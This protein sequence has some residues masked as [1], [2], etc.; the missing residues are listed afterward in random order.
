MSLRAASQKQTSKAFQMLTALYAGGIIV[1]QS[2]GQR[3]S[4]VGLITTS[5]PLCEALCGVG[6]SAVSACGLHARKRTSRQGQTSCSLTL[7]VCVCVC[8]SVRVCKSGH[9]C[10]NVCVCV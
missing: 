1:V 9:V 7:D 10:E 3:D 8:M 2:G 6:K 5:S 4:A